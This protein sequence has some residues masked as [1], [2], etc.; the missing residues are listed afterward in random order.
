MCIL[1]IYLYL[2]SANLNSLF[3]RYLVPIPLDWLSIGRP[4]TKRLPLTRYLAFL[5]PD[6]TERMGQGIW[7]NIYLGTCRLSGAYRE[8]HKMSLKEGG[9]KDRATPLCTPMQI[10]PQ[11]YKSKLI[12]KSIHPL[13]RKTRSVSIS[14]LPSTQCRA[15]VE[16]PAPPPPPLPP[17]NK[18]I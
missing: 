17:D 7:D 13:D 4:R 16:R 9:A 11:I 10:S 12:C 2:S 6:H 18:L 8:T 15:F 3:L 5:T 1:Y 14:D